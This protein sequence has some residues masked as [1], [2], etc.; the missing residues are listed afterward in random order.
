MKWNIIYHI[1]IEMLDYFN[2]LQTE[3]TQILIKIG[4][5]IK[6]P[7]DQDY[8][9]FAISWKM[10]FIFSLNAREIPIIETFYANTFKIY[11]QIF[12]N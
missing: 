7:K 3:C 9:R 6:I 2:K 5:N 10:N 11:I 8:V 1:H 12:L 4:R